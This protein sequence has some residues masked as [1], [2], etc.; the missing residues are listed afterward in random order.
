[1]RKTG[2]YEKLESTEN[3]GNL[4]LFPRP[5]QLAPR[6]PCQARTRS[7]SAAWPPGA[8]AQLRWLNHRWTPRIPKI[9]QFKLKGNQDRVA[10]S[11][12]VSQ[13]GPPSCERNHLRK[14]SGLLF[15]HMGAPVWDWPTHFFCYSHLWKS[16]MPVS[17]A[18]SL[19]AS[20]RLCC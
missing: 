19:F 13:P 4:T 7:S 17:A 9:T 1:M 8:Q 10:W 16:V 5:S 15:G 2:N 6:A 3:C 12:M 20:L 11:I 14:C 18:S